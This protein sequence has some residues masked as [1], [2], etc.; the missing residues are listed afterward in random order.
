MRLNGQRKDNGDI[1]WPPVWADGADPVKPGSYVLRLLFNTE[2]ART[3]MTR[4]E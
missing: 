1:Y 4:E 2:E 3:A